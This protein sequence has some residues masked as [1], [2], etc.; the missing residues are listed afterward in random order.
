MSG[1]KA[2]KVRAKINFECYDHEAEQE[3]SIQAGETAVEIEEDENWPGF[4]QFKMDLS[5]ECVFIHP[6]VA[7]K[8][9]FEII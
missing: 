4:A 1:E 6:A 8:L 9:Y 3:I 7:Y 5:G 2:K